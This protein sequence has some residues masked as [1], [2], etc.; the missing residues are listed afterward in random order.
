MKHVQIVFF[1]VFVA[2][3]AYL[4]L[5]PPAGATP[6]KRTAQGTVITYWEKW[7]GLEGSQMQEI[8]KD[9]NNTVGKEKGI[10]VQYL[11]MSKIDQKTLIATAAGIPPDVAGV[12]D[13]Q[14][15]QFAALD[16]LEPLDDYAKA[17]GISRDMYKPVYWDAMVYEGKLWGLVSTPWAVALHYNKR[18]FQEN[19]EALKRAGLDPNRAPATLQELDRYAEVLDIQHA[20]WY[21]E[22]VLEKNAEALKAA[23]LDA[24]KQPTTAEELEKYVKVLGVPENFFEGRTLEKYAERLKAAGLDPSRQPRDLPEMRRYV[25]ICGLPDRVS[26]RMERAGYLPAEPGWFMSHT[27][28][29]FG[30]SVYDAKTDKLTLTDEGVV[31]AYEWMESYTKRLGRKAANDFKSGMQDVFASAQNAFL[32]GSVVMEKQG[33][34]MVNYT[35]DLKPSM[36][37]WNVPKDELEREKNFTDVK[38]GMSVGEVETLLGPGQGAGDKRTWKAGI[39]TLHATIADGKVR[40]TSWK[41]LPAEER[42]KY[43]EWGTAEFPS[44][45]PGVQGATYAGYDVLVIPRGSKHKKEAFEFIAYI[46][47]QEVQE[48]LCSLHCK[49]SVLRKVSKEFVSNHQNPY[50]DVYERIS[51]GSN[52]R[53]LPGIPIWP[54]VNAELGQVAEKAVKLSQEPRQA[55]QEA[56]ERLEARYAEFKRRQAER[57]RLAGI[58]K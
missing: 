32:V 2:A 29:W 28:Y 35:E 20:H 16:A 23:G 7:T 18:T 57:K 52:A 38:V 4:L 1:T 14:L 34:W 53:C 51:A 40:E 36:D 13:T 42:K 45:I 50:I 30:A 58:V 25:L 54:E 6:A 19:A 26:G 49:N 56:Q 5:F 55:L 12:W 37:R 21:P 39:K 43:F 41:W 9:F 15:V 24:T 47:R 22:E 27:A 33:P 44:A 48:K 3:V 11:S 17:Y 46:Q 31:R 10:Y 8:V